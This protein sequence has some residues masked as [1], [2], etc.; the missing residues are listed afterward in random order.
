[1]FAILTFMKK[2]FSCL[3]VCTPC[4]ACLPKKQ[5]ALKGNG[6]I[7]QLITRRKNVCTTLQSLLWHRLF[8]FKLNSTTHIQC[9]WW[10]VCDGVP[11]TRKGLD[12]T[13]E[14]LGQFNYCYLWDSYIGVKI[15]KIASIERNVFKYYLSS[16]FNMGTMDTYLYFANSQG[17]RDK[18]FE[19]II[20]SMDS[21]CCHQAGCHGP[22]TSCFI[23]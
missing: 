3:V 8:N 10:S 18:L 20:I 5:L 17:M 19:C 16:I 23:L 15:M 6:W 7:W 21:Y 4:V 13:D 2:K 12:K 9:V 14:R 1:M 22:W 11:I